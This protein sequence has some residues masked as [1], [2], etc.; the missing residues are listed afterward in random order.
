MA[1]Y[2]P[3]QDEFKSAFLAELVSITLYLP[4]LVGIL[5]SCETAG[6]KIM[7]GSIIVGRFFSML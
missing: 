4:S 7:I 5:I 2:G 3:A 6:R 1:V